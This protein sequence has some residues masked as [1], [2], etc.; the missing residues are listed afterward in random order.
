LSAKAVASATTTEECTDGIHQL[1]RD[2]S[3]LIF[4]VASFIIKPFIITERRKVTAGTR[5][6]FS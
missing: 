1:Q 3:K 5:I 4:P 6:I 2:L